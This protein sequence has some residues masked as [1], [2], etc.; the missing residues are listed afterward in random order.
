MDKINTIAIL[1]QTDKVHDEASARKAYYRLAQQFH[2]DK[3]PEGRERFEEVNR[4]YEFLCSRTSWTSHGPDPNNIVL[5][6]KTQSIL[7]D[8]YQ[9]D[10]EP[11]KYAGYPQLVKTIKIE[12]GNKLY[13]IHFFFLFK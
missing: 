13:Y 5:I 4:A 9:Y 1:F 10:L 6:L 2:P 3:N 11:Y 8:R 7:F 12:A